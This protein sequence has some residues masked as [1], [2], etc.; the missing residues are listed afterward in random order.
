[1]KPATHPRNKNLTNKTQAKNKN[2]SFPHFLTDLT[3]TAAAFNR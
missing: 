3:A 2:P 1:M